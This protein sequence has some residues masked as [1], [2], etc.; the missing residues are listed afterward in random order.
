MVGSRFPLRHRM[1]I[2]RYIPKTSYYK[3]IGI[4]SVDLQV[5]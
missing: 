4:I 2:G 5:S 3:Y 1:L